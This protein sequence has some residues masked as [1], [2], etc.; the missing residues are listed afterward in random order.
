MASVFTQIIKKRIPGYIIA[1]ET[2]YIAFLDIHPIASGHTLVVPKKEVSY[3][4]DLDPETFTGLM[5]F[6]KKMAVGMKKILPC[7]R[8][9]MTVVG[10]EVPH[11]HIHLVPI[12]DL[13]DMDFKKSKLQ[14][15][16]DT[17]NDMAQKLRNILAS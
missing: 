10:L 11:A 6:A 14:Q 13:Y 5:L 15:H 2:N 9:G 3:L 17:L 12:N 4:F 1:E 7:L 16:P 8:I